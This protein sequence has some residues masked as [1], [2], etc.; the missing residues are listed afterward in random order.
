[1]YARIK[2]GVA[3]GEALAQ[4]QTLEQRNRD[5]VAEPAMR[6]FYNGG[7]QMGLACCGGADKID[8][9]RSA[10]ALR[11]RSPCCCQLE[12]AAYVAA[13]SPA[14]TKLPQRTAPAPSVVTAAH[15]RRRQQACWR[16]WARTGH[17]RRTAVINLPDK[18][19][20]IPPVR[21]DADARP[22]APDFM[23]SHS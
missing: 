7:H 8:Q 19:L 6:E 23:G 9:E 16:A 5:L 21:L 17:W 11:R 2:P 14:P 13:P 15:L 4:L 1:M 3:H 10:P 20:G 18:M 12:T 22:D